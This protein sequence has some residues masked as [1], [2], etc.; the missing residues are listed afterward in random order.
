MEE[1]YVKT[2]EHK[3]FDEP[4]R[5]FW[6]AETTYP[7]YPVLSENLNVDVAIVGGGIA[8]I[9]SAYWL[10][11]EGL[12]TAV[13]EAD[14]ILRGTTGHTTA[15]ITSQHGLIYHKTKNG[16]G[17]ELARQ[18]AIANES[19]IRMIQKIVTENHIDCDYMPQSAYVYTL[20]D[21]YVDKIYD[22][23][24]T[25][26][27][28]G[29]KATYAEETPLPF[30]VK[31]AVR[32][33]N[34]AQFHPLKFLLA[35]TKEMTNKGTLIFEQTRVVDIEENGSYILTTDKGNKITAKKVI[36]ASHYPFYNKPAIYF[37]RIYQK[38]SYVVAVKTKEKYTGGMYISAEDPTRSLRN[39]P[40]G[41]SE[42][43]LV[44]GENHKSGQGKDEAAHYEA[45]ADFADEIFT[46]EDIPYRWSTQ[47]CITLD[48]IPYV[49]HFTSKT[50]NM[51]ITTGFQKWGMTNSMASAMLLRDLIIHGKSP[52]QDVYTPSRKISPLSAK[53]FVV[54]NLNVA[55]EITKGK[56][57]PLSKDIELNPGEA[58]I[59]ELE[60]E[61][62]GA[63]RDEEGTL[64]LVNTTCPH[65]GCEL[66]W[67][68]AEKSWDCP[69]HGSRFSYKGDIIEGPSVY[70]LSEDHDVNT[71][72]KVI[73]EDF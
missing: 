12:R 21:K 22:E 10:S 7:E 38:R 27:S 71:I 67:N 35:L 32:F 52:W 60:G 72:K 24:K 68:E 45:L 62:T 53:N 18:Y 31:A 43:I 9:T 54:Q 5:S 36:I 49:G 50:P 48:N 65:M 14:H 70:S 47:D 37:A 2:K 11:K 3:T 1:Y 56:L 17:E 39:Q 33:D 66:F 29:I 61:R 42:L 44:G 20:Q 28:L 41:T 25:A 16:L 46:V 58:R 19:A 69:C 15:K 4:P 34:Q 63:Y 40:F 73:T 59:I 30:K 51:Y 8:G 13:I 23:A 6:L 64:Y 26:A 57:S 55:F